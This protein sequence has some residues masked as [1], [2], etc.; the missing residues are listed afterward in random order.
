MAPS[1][2]YTVC[3]TIDH[4]RRVKHNLEAVISLRVVWILSRV[5]QHVFQSVVKYVNSLLSV[6][7]NVKEN[8]GLFISSSVDCFHMF[9]V[10]ISAVD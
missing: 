7:P 3:C 5:C 9:L 4:N 8:Q 2:V 6:F 1:V 10:N